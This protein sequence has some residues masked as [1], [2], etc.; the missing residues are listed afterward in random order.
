MSAPSKKRA[1][2]SLVASFLV[3]VLLTLSV[4]PLLVDWYPKLK[5]ADLD[6]RYTIP[7][8]FRPGVSPSLLSKDS[9]DP[10][11]VP[12]SSRVYKYIWQ[13]AKDKSDIPDKVKERIKQYAPNYDYR[14]HDDAE[15][16]AFLAENF[17]QD[18]V[19]KYRGFKKG[20]H[21]ADLWR[22]CVLYIYGGVYMDIETVLMRNIDEILSD[23]S[24][25]VSYTVLS[26]IPDTIMQG[27]IAV[28]ARTEFMRKCID[29][30]MKVSED[31]ID[32]DYLLHTRK[33]F[34]RLKDLFR[35][36][37]VVGTMWV[38]K[39]V[40]GKGKARQKWIL[41]RED[42][43]QKDFSRCGYQPDRYGN[44]CVIR[45]K[46]NRPMMFTRYPDFP[47]NGILEHDAVYRYEHFKGAQKHRKSDVWVRASIYLSGFGLSLSLS[48]LT[49][50]WLTERILG[51]GVGREGRRVE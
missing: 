12:D 4:V 1:F 15:G 8:R 18:I 29:D 11:D 10:G 30:V 13:T 34:K 7:V 23:A 31:E 6:Q 20:A 41:H 51:L 14:V 33:F 35:N 28:P 39:D 19:D 22:Y 50:E 47:W 32:F 5:A 25:S 24:Q 36:Y 46:Y 44:C 43:D 45:D 37:P 42:C 40:T 38:S 16:E 26:V 27:F 9:A 48:S 49:V 3:G 2:L 17:E 21:K